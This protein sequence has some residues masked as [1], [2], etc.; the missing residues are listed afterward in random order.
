M[1]KLR[2]LPEVGMVGKKRCV[3]SYL[4]QGHP[5]LSTGLDMTVLPYLFTCMPAGVCA[6]VCVCVCQLSYYRGN[7][8]L[9]QDFVLFY[10][11]LRFYLF[12]YS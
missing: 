12:I 9:A 7:T 4:R 6:C 11:F 2:V 1:P 3:L 5:G 8:V 10:F